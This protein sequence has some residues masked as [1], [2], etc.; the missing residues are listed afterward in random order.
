MTD[1]FKLN[2]EI[3]EVII[4]APVTNNGVPRETVFPINCFKPGSKRNWKKKTDHDPDFY[5]WIN[6]YLENTKTTDELEDIYDFYKKAKT[7]IDKKGRD[8]KVFYSGI[9]EILNEIFNR[10]DIL[11]YREWFLN[12]V[13][14]VVP[15]GV[16]E[17]MDPTKVQEGSMYREKTFL[18]NDYREVIVVNQILRLFIPIMSYY[19]MLYG[20]NLVITKKY[21]IYFSW[22]LD[23][24]NDFKDLPGYIKIINYG[25][26]MKAP[27]NKYSRLD[28]RSSEDS[29]RLNKDSTMAMDGV[30]KSDRI[31]WE[32]SRLLLTDFVFRRLHAITDEKNMVVTLYTVVTPSDL[33]RVTLSNQYHKKRMSVLDGEDDRPTVLENYKTGTDI[34]IGNIEEMD[35]LSSDVNYV[36]D[37]LGLDGDGI[38]LEKMMDASRA[39]FNHDT[40]LL[41]DCQ[42][43]LISVVIGKIMDPETVL[44]V[45]KESMIVLMA[46][47]KTWLYKNGFVDLCVLL[48]TDLIMEK[49]VTNIGSGYTLSGEHIAALHKFYP[50]LSTAHLDMSNNREVKLIQPKS[51]K[52]IDISNTGHMF[53]V[54][55]SI[56]YMANEFSK[57]KWGNY[58]GSGEI[59]HESQ[60]SKN[61]HQA[62]ANLAVLIK[63]MCL[64]TI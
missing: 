37:M 32:I 59:Y 12:N 46:V 63:D 40:L 30:S 64:K 15:I 27:S 29:T 7:L 24:N 50:P 23:K 28:Y 49:T 54:A 6:R 47:T 51:K 61:M 36:A 52:Q 21:H 26:A 58:Y 19:D 9:K 39:F 57:Y 5:Y 38:L 48:T 16:Y 20:S 41:K 44:Y 35:F 43:N 11:A 55:T 53:D 18:A 17:E 34:S 42:R 3:T 56:C 25:E 31:T 33:S 45:G 1:L 13:S 4:S 60:L 14:I 2:E 22:L 62:R 8:R 10:I